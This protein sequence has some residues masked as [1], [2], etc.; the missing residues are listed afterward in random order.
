MSTL[1]EEM[2]IFVK[3]HDFL[4]WL[5]PQTNHF[6]RLHRHTVTRRLLDAAFDFQERI[7]E[8]NSLRGQ[9]RL[10]RLA[11]ADAQLNKVRLYLRLVHRLRWL[12]LGQY[13]H[14]ANMVTELG[15]LLGGW[16]KVTEE[17][18]TTPAA[19]GR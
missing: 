10:E 9:T 3:T 2:P 6:P 12:T 18:A 1:P 5:V 15:K 17:K 11:H 19:R 7:L 16:R 14:A 4:A 8:A 13:H